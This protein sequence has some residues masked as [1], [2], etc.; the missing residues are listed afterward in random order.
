MPLHK[1]SRWI[2]IV[3]CVAIA[4]FFGPLALIVAGNAG[5]AVL[6]SL[7]NRKPTPQELVGHYELRVPWGTSTL[8]IRPDG[9]FHE[10]IRP[11]DKPVKVV[12]GQWH[13]EQE[14]PN[15]LSVEFK[16][17]GMV[18]DEDHDRNI[19]SYLIEFRQPHLGATYGLIN[20]DLGEA[21]KRQ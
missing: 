9:T 21:F 13:N 14:G 6:D 12:S 15:Y 18:W 4:L 1:I 3:S 2:L 17:F 11:N 5:G 7:L 16:P 19:G 8:Q 10:E 20:D